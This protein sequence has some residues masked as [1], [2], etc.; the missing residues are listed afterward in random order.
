MLKNFSKSKTPQ[1]STKWLSASEKSRKAMVENE[2]KKNKLYKDF[3]IIKVPDN[4]QIVIKINKSIPSN[5]RG[6]FLLELE[7][8]IKYNIDRG[9]TIW[10]EPVG[11]KSALRKLRGVK[12]K[13]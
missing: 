8:K 7:E 6:L 12:I 10:C 9:I 11:D 1:T 13:S 4:G 2:L 3:E 5:K